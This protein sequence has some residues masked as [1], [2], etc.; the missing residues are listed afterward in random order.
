MNCTIFL[1][2][3]EKKEPI[4]F[5]EGQTDQQ[6]NGGV[7]PPP[8]EHNYQLKSVTSLRDAELQP[9]GAQR[10]AKQGGDEPADW[11]E[12]HHGQCPGTSF[13]WEGVWRGAFAPHRCLKM[14]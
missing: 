4:S 3:Q 7:K 5:V 8:H 6:T 1:T 10:S 12:A 9:S 11:T 2:F 14:S 13:G